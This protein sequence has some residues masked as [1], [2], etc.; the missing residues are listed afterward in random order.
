MTDQIIIN[1]GG[2]NRWSESNSDEKKDFENGS[3][4]NLSRVN[5]ML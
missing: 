4:S 3:E 2:P 1:F 5:E